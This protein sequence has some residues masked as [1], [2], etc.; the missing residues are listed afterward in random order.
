MDYMV[1]ESLK[2]YFKTHLPDVEKIDEKLEQLFSNESS[3][4]PFDDNESKKLVELIESVKI[5]DP[6]VGSGA[7]PMGTLNK[8]VFILNKVDPGNKLWKEAQL[9]AADAIPDPSARRMA[10]ERIKEFFEGKNAD[11]GRKLYLIQR[12]IYGVDI[13]QIAVEIAK[14]RFFISLLVDEKIDKDKDNWGI[15]PLPNLDFKIMQGNSLISEFLGID[16]DNSNHDKEQ[17][18]TGLLFA[19]EDNSLIKEFE[20]KKIDFQNEADK[21]KKAKLKQEVENLMIQIFETKVK[22]Q[23]GDYFR[24]LEEIESK[25]SLLPNQKQRDEI[26]AQEKQKL[27]KKSGFDLENIEKQLREFTSK[28]KTRPFFPWKLYFA[29]VFEKGGFDVVIANPPYVSFGLRDTQK[30]GNT[31]RDLLIKKY[32]DSAEYKISLYAIFMDRAIQLANKNGGVQT[33][34]VPDSFL[35]GR[36]FSKIRNNI[37][38]NCHIIHISWLPYKIFEATVG[39]SVIYTFQKFPNPNLNNRIITRHIISNEQIAQKKY[40][41]YKYEQLYFKKQKH[42]RF[43]LFFD[44]YTMDIVTKVENKTIPLGDI[45]DFNSGLIGKDGKKSIVSSEKK[46][47]DWLPGIISGSEILR[48]ILKP[49]GYFLLYKKEKIH[50]GFDCVNYFEDKI[51]MRQTGDSLISAIDDIHLL[52][53]NNV[54]VGNLK[55]NKYSLK[56]VT[57]VINSAMMNYFYKSLALE[58][59]RTMAQTD[60]E[61]IESLPIKESNEKKQQPFIDLVDCI[62]SITKGE[63]YLNNL[64][65]QATVKEYEKQ[66][67]QMVYNLYGLTKEEIDVIESGVKDR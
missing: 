23:K 62:L 63:D 11:Y 16:F 25:Y 59:G 56:Y 60:I 24:Q 43:R 57:A 49:Q 33:Y 58:E 22:K 42:N 39:F 8:L 3:D 64:A 7:F 30:L 15:E 37:L 31:E 1:A 35:L 26:I 13:Q 54:H 34:I 28:K 61:T 17:A 41:Q 51:F 36:Y 2:A 5:V 66:I 10:K 4:N 45:I 44:Q 12:C 47:K 55:D 18:Q 20:Q 67:D 38:N 50:S 46:N 14:L 19:D 6:A 52:C 32:P 40:K 53:L 29:E 21:D 48:Y 27:S 9:K 65:K